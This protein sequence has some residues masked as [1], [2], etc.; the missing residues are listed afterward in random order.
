MIEAEA[1]NQPGQIGCARVRFTGVRGGPG[2]DGSQA[3]CD[4]LHDARQVQD[5]QDDQHQRDTELHGE[6]DPWRD[7][8]AE[9]D[10]ECAYGKDGYGVSKAP[11]RPDECCPADASLPADNGRDGDHMV[12]VRRVPHAEQ[13]AKSDDEE[14]GA[15]ALLC[16]R[17]PAEMRRRDRLHCHRDSCLHVLKGGA[18]IEV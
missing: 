9:E 4:L 13:E 17:G 7:L 3:L 2:T 10:D 8:Y 14:Y 15:E 18:E 11:D 1:S 5:A 12:R 16:K 6:P